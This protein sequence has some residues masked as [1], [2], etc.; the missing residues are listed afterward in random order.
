MTMWDLSWV[1]GSTWENQLMWKKHIHGLKKRTIT[2]ASQQMQEKH[3]TIFRNQMDQKE[4]TPAWERSYLQSHSRQHTQWWENEIF[5]SQSRT[6]P[7]EALF[8]VLS[9]IVLD[10]LTRKWEA[11]TISQWYIHLL[12]VQGPGFDSYM[13]NKWNNIDPFFLE[14]LKNLTLIRENKTLPGSINHTSWF[15]KWLQSYNH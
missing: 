5:P 4:T 6:K 10:I 1:V 9:K 8:L 14:K 11:W 3:L 13:G 15:Q 12:H 7:G 2:W